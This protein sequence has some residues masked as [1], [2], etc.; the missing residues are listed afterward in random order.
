METKELTKKL[1][2]AEV[3]IESIENLMLKNVKDIEATEQRLKKA[4]S[5]SNQLKEQH[6]SARQKRQGL[7]VA[8]KDAQAIS[9]I[10]KDIRAE[11]EEREDEV[12]GLQKKQERLE[13]E[14]VQLASDKEEAR[15]D[16]LR[17]KLQELVPRYNETALKLSEIVKEI[18]D[19]KIKLHDP[20]NRAI[21]SSM[22]WDDNALEKIPQL[23]LPGEE[24]NK[25]SFFNRYTYRQEKI[26]EISEV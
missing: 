5:R 11:S 16:F 17:M 9:K 1:Q 14:K 7:L 15:K 19:L 2:E 20:N 12:I 23:R 10:I 4:E 21:G 13:S 26:K 18:H 22:G 3:N 24:V 8:G 6:E 25:Y